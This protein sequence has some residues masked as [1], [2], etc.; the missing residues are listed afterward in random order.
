M[1]GLFLYHDKFFG[2]IVLLKNVGDI[3]K[4]MEFEM[5]CKDVS[6]KHMP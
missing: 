6:L 1:F 4:P 5:R 3:L 2:Q